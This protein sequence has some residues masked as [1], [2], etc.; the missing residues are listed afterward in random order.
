MRHMDKQ[1]LRRLLDMTVY[2][3]HI[4]LLE[5]GLPRKIQDVHL[6]NGD[7]SIYLTVYIGRKRKKTFIFFIY[8]SF[9]FGS[10]SWVEWLP[11]SGGPLCQVSLLLR[12]EA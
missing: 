10:S 12:R 5:V 8:I 6:K 9:Q 1:H 3:I 4:I 7:F 2:P 11:E